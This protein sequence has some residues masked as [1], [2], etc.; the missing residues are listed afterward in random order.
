M[1]FALAL[2]LIAD[3]PKVT[4]LP[5]PPLPV[6]PISK[7]TPS[8]RIPMDGPSDPNDQ[9]LAQLLCTNGK[10]MKL[11]DCVVV[12]A[13]PAEFGPIAV[14]RAQ[15]MPPVP[16][17]MP[18]GTPLGPKLIVVVTGTGIAMPPRGSRPPAPPPATAP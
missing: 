17:A 16:P 5:G 15:S 8:I 3:P 6:P 18:D 14:Q 11:E 12:Q 7:P 10:T 13:R 4:V 9:R 2:L 1:M